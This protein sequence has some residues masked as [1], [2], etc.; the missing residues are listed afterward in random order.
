[1]VLGHLDASEVLEPL[2]LS[3]SDAVEVLEP[4]SPRRAKNAKKKALRV[5]GKAKEKE[6][7]AAVGDTKT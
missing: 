7:A 2:V 6:R 3:Q 1:L 5:A 4:L